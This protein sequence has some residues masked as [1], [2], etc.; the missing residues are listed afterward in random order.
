MNAAPAALTCLRD[1]GVMV[2]MDRNEIAMSH[3]GNCLGW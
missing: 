3:C 1:G 2:A